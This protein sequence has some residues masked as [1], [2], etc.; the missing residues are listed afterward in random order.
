MR[1]TKFYTAILTTVMVLNICKY[2]MPYIEYN[3]FRD[4]IAGNLCIQ[5]NVAGN[6]CQGQ[7]YLERQIDR[8]NETGENTASGRTATKQVKCE[9][10]DCIKTNLF[11]PIQIP[12]IKTKQSQFVAV[13]FA[14][15]VIEIP[16]PP[17]QHF[18]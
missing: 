4:Y 10:F 2:Q 14:R 6:C 15:V 7:C 17:P 13:S 18:C 11:S 12:F 16:V 3:L 1:H 9:I 8:V 5:K